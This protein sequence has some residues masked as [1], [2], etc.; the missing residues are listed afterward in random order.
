MG[1]D[2][3]ARK[4]KPG[5]KHSTNAPVP[6]RICKITR[7]PSPKMECYPY[8][9]QVKSYQQIFGALKKGKSYQQISYN[10]YKP[11]LLKQQ[12]SIGPA[13]DYVAMKFAKWL[14]GLFK[15]IYQDEE[16]RPI[17][18][19]FDVIPTVHPFT[20]GNDGNRITNPD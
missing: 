1:R 10:L 3:M 5:D 2:W 19:V 17:I 8:L 11:D 7:S 12:T 6:I 9:L 20:T 4:C 13:N 15:T 18:K 14:N 16:Q